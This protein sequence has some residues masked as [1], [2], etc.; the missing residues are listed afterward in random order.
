MKAI[1]AGFSFTVLLILLMTGAFKV[2]GQ[3]KALNP[4]SQIALNAQGQQA[5]QFNA[6]DLTVN[7]TYVRTGGDMQLTGNVQFGM[8]I[9]AN[10][11]VVQTF[12]LGLAMADAQGNV[13]G[14]QGVTTAYDNNVGDTINFSTSV[15]VP[16]QTAS[17]AFTY[18]GQAYA[19][20]SGGGPDPTNFSF[21]PFTN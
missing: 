16:A 5:G 4:A 1:V 7:Y 8:T 3:G 21:Y 14:E 17:M 19:S 10:Y 11:S 6:P 12:Q 9:Q 2:Y 15:V 13:L 20:G 18:T